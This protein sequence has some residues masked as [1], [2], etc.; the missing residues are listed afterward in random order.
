MLKLPVI[1]LASTP[2]DL[3][4]QSKGVLF[5]YLMR[6]LCKSYIG[7]RCKDQL[8]DLSLV[9]FCMCVLRLKCHFLKISKPKLLHML[10]CSFSKTGNSMTA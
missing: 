1:L 3:N 8:V 9:N 4:I 7:N 6:L 2:A 5:Y 10:V